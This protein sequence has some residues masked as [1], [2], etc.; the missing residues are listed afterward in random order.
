MSIGIP[1]IQSALQ[2]EI[3]PPLHEHRKFLTK[4]PPRQLLREDPPIQV[5]TVLV[6]LN[7]LSTKHPA[8]QHGLMLARQLNARLVV[9]HVLESLYLLVCEASEGFMGPLN[10]TVKKA[11]KELKKLTAKTGADKG[12]L[13]EGK[14][15]DEILRAAREE[16]AGLI[17]VGHHERSKLERLCG[18]HLTVRVLDLAPCPVI[19]VPDAAPGRN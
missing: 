4:R 5:T 19:C 9:V 2:V 10:A 8:M 7:H 6:A 13:R 16:G 18:R 3:N 11:R 14:I 1:Q 15:E 12:L 17:I